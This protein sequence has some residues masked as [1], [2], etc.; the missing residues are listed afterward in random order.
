MLSPFIVSLILA[1][2]PGVIAQNTTNTTS[3][4]EELI[5][6]PDHVGR[7]AD[8]PKDSEFVFDFLKPPAASVVQGAAGHLVL[9]SVAAF[10]ALVG[11]G[12]ALLAGFLGPCGMNTPHTH[13]RATEFLYLV[14]GTLQ[15]GMITETGSRFVVNN[16]TAG[17]GMLLPQGSIHFQFNDNCEPVQFVSAL[18]SE[19]PGTLLAAQGLFGLPAAIVAATLGE[20]GVEEVASLAEMIPDDVAYGSQE[21]LT[22]CGISVGPGAQPTNEQVPRVSGNTLPSESVSASTTTAKS[23]AKAEVTNQSRDL[24]GGLASDDE[25]E[26][27]VV[28]GDISYNSEKG[29]GDHAALTALVILVMAM[30]SGY[31]SLAVLFYVRRNKAAKAH[32]R[33][34]AW[35]TSEAMETAA[36]TSPLEKYG[37]D[38]ES[39]RFAGK[40]S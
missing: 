40:S 13:P 34:P 14:N 23:T 37:K 7:V 16:I 26:Q 22:R 36:L 6:A 27:P 17:Q 2:A 18:N 11:N 25:S 30:G 21:C 19:D 9:A 8:L 24:L 29:S 33:G 35:A 38:E 3:L 1:I 32:G 39:Y 4:I 12:V 28:L 10:P 31:I 15:N 20:I 5:V